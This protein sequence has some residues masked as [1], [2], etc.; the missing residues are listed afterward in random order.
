[1]E[2]RM[3]STDMLQQRIAEAACQIDCGAHA[4]SKTGMFGKESNDALYEMMY[5]SKF[6]PFW[7]AKARRK[8]EC[9]LN[10]NFGL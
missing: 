3:Y 10:D 1:M 2:V 7:N 5:I 4:M 9:Y 8:A 6:L